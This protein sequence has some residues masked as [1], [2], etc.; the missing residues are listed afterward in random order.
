MVEFT[1]RSCVRRLACI[2]ACAYVSNVI[3]E[4]AWRGGSSTTLTFSL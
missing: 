1:I 2:S 3:L 4:L